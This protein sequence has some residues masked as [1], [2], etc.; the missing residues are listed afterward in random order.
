MKMLHYSDHKDDN[1]SALYEECDVL[2]STGDLSIFDFPGLEDWEDRKQAF[3]VYGNHDS[4][5][6]MDR[7][8]ILNLHNNVEEF[9]GL[10]WGGFQWCLKYKK[11]DSPQYT[12]EARRARIQGAVTLKVIIESNGSVRVVE[13]LHG[14]PMGLTE[15][16]IKAAEK[17]KFQPPIV[18]GVPVAVTYELTLH[19]RIQ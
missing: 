16:A 6:Y 2:V 10:R 11:G 1:F 3:G 9:R 17:W 5:M 14:L 18:D 15:A 12:E 13:V 7:L 8:G 19:F 4:G